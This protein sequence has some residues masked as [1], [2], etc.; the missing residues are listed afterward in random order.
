[1]CTVCE[2]VQD[3][4]D[5][6]GSLVRPDGAVAQTVEHHDGIVGAEGS[7]P[8]C[9]TLRVQDHTLGGFV[10]GEGCFYTV[11]NGRAWSDGDPIRKFGFK[12]SV[13]TRDRAL[14]EALRERL[15]AGSIHDTAPGQ[16]HWQP[17]STLTIHS[18]R[19]HRIATVPFMDRY[20]IAGA[21]RRQYL[22]WKQEMVDYMARHAIRAGGQPLR[23]SVEGCDRPL[24]G[25][26]LC[27]RHYYRE[28]GW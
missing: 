1:M 20:L 10:A 27:R 23:C 9:S 14:L 22:A 17:Q 13:A 21:K 19:A 28:T 24:R 11:V 5:E 12:V 2:R 7:S 15:G 16:P 6:S 18:L 26:R 4:L 25:R 3:E 8:S